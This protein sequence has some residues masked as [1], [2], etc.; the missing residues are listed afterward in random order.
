[1]PSHISGPQVTKTFLDTSL[2]KD[3]LVFYSQGKW[4][5]TKAYTPLTFSAFCFLPDKQVT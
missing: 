2:A 5:A 3:F 4:C 1:M